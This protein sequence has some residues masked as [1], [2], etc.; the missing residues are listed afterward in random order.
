MDVP[1]NWLWSP[2]PEFGLNARSHDATAE[3]KAAISACQLILMNV[4]TLLQKMFIILAT[5]D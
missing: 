4:I 5:S 1:G 3:W 2:H